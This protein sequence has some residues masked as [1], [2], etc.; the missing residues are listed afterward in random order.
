MPARVPTDVAFAV[1]LVAPV[2]THALRGT[3]CTPVPPQVPTSDINESACH[4]DGRRDATPAEPPERVH[5]VSEQ[6]PEQ[7]G[8]LAQHLTDVAHEA[9]DAVHV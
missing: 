5:R 3:L 2:F 1:L 6:L 9:L 7:V 4:Y 8:R